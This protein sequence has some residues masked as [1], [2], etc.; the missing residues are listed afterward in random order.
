MQKRCWQPSLNCHRLETHHTR[1]A[2]RDNRNGS[3]SSLPSCHMSFGRGRQC[4]QSGFLLAYH[5]V[6]AMIHPLPSCSHHRLIIGGEKRH[7]CTDRTAAL[8]L[9]FLCTAYMMSLFA[10]FLHDSIERKSWHTTQHCRLPQHKSSPGRTRGGNIVEGPDVSDQG[11]KSREE[12]PG[13]ASQA[14][15][16]TP[17]NIYSHSKCTRG[18]GTN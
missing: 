17:L 13:S 7:S 8:G 1:Q 18:Q 9:D 4:P 2:P 10:D 16:T 3:P 11:G 12:H 15:L 5:S 14:C 6:G